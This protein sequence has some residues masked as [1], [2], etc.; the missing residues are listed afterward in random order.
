[1]KAWISARG[2]V[3]GRGNSIG[4][5]ILTAAN[6]GNVVIDA[7]ARLVPACLAAANPMWTS[8]FLKVF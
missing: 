6:C 3:R 4:D 2:S 1:M 5:Y 7:V 8:L